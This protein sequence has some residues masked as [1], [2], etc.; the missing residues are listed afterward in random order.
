MEEENLGWIPS[1][2][3]DV[4][5]LGTGESIEVQWEVFTVLRMRI[6]EE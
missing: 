6:W 4:V 1:W 2:D 5:A 3:V